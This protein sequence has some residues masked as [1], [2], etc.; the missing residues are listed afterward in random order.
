MMTRWISLNLSQIRST[1]SS[2]K[3]RSAAFSFHVAPAAE[4]LHRPVGD[5]T[6]HL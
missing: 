3:W 1:R 2:R 6:C 5:A 4:D